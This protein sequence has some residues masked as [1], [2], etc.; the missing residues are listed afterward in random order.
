MGWK[1]W[2]KKPQAAAPQADMWPTDSVAAVRK[3]IGLYISEVPP[4]KQW[5]ATNAQLTPE[6]EKIAE[7]GARGLA[8]GMWFW[9]FA[10]IHGD[11]AMQMAIDTF[12]NLLDELTGE[13]KA[14]EQT[15][16][17]LAFIDN[18]RQGFSDMPNE[19]RTRVVNGETI[20]VTFPW[21]LA[22]YLLIQLPNSPYE[23]KDDVRDADLDVALCLAQATE[24]AQEFWEPM[25]AAIGPFNPAS[26]DTWRWSARPGAFER[27]LQRRHNNP[28]FPEARRIVTAAD[29][30]YARVRDAQEIQEVGRA[31]H[32]IYEELGKGDLPFDWHPHLNGLRE[33]LD[34]AY[35]ALQRAGGDDHLEQSWASI[36]K[37]VMDVWRTALGNNADALAGLDLAEA[38][39]AEGFAEAADFVNQLTH[40]GKPIPLEEIAPA[41]LTEPVEQVTKTVQRLGEGKALADLRK[42]ALQVV[43]GA[44]ADGG[45]VPQHRE[46]LAA[47]GVGI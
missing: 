5:Q 17:L 36:R 33:Q 40:P 42:L 32:A 2:E 3:L 35:D 30:Y 29:V 16:K 18:A 37:H 21:Y 31:L 4:F 46:K 19:Q 9:Q 12:C 45:E 39:A 7:I 1:F 14:G 20:E 28:L 8:L 47:L 15:Y 41:L 10:A 34:E 13:D 6:T 26:Y 25:L 24:R 43:L 11:I 44:L 23:G 38:G 22:L 27:H